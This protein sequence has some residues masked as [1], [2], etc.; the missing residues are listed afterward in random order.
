[1]TPPQS[2]PGPTS[3]TASR[4]AG[5]AVTG[6]GEKDEATRLLDKIGQHVNE[7]PQEAAMLP[8]PKEKQR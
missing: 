1:M 3:S 7:M 6:E 8:E 4:H 5:T 2:T